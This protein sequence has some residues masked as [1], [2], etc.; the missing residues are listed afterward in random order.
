MIGKRK[1]I[2][3]AGITLS[4]MIGIAFV[5]A[6]GFPLLISFSNVQSAVAQLLRTDDAW[7][8]VYERLPDIPKENQYVNRETGKVDPD[9]TLVSRLIRYHVY[10]KGRPPFYRLDWKMTMAD[11]LGINGAMEDGIY[12]SHE[13]LRKNPIDGDIAAIKQLNR[14]QRNALIQALVDTFTSQRSPRSSSPAPP[15][16]GSPKPEN[17]GQ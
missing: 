7:R 3:R 15:A 1:R 16:T 11:Y 12:P 8:S 5:G 14:V 10:V 17:N 2:R 6:I 9:N 13:T 4:L